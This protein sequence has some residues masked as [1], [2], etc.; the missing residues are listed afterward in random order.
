MKA[1]NSFS[2]LSISS[3]QRLQQA[4]ILCLEPNLILLAEKFNII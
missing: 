3:L 1:D 2:Y 4:A